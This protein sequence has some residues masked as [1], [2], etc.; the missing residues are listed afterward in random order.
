MFI[1][2]IQGLSAGD[3]QLPAAIPQGCLASIASGSLLDQV[4]I[5]GRLLGVG[6]L[7][8][9]APASVVDGRDRSRLSDEDGAYEGI[10]DANG[11]VE[12][13]HDS[14]ELCIWEPGEVPVPCLRRANRAIHVTVPFGDIPV[15]PLG[16]LNALRVMRAGCAGRQWLT[17]WL[18]QPS[19]NPASVVEMRLRLRRA[20]LWQVSAGGP[21]ACPNML[22]ERD[23]AINP[24]TSV[25]YTSMGTCE[26]QT[27]DVTG[28]IEFELYLAANDAADAFWQVSVELEDPR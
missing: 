18:G 9:V 27:F 2:Q 20:G 5:D 7:V 6:G 8:P 1:V 3:R 14:A 24:G 23:V 10:R 11:D 19:L 16:N 4:R 25:I 13:V 21:G 12:Q 15:T 22:A 28:A 17:V 26:P